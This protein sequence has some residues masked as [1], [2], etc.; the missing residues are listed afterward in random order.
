MT[1]PHIAT[2]RDENA[3]SHDAPSSR[4]RR[5]PQRPDQHQ[6]TNRDERDERDDEFAHLTT[7]PRPPHTVTNNRRG[8]SQMPTTNPGPVTMIVAG[9]PYPPTLSTAQTAQLWG[10][11]PE[12]LYA[13]LGRGTLPVEPLALGKRYRWPTLRV[14]EVLSLPIEIVHQGDAA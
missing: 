13:E 10:C 2:R 9:T 7:E 5:G 6:R 12:R 11:S 14:A 8:T 1:R 4:A 3:T